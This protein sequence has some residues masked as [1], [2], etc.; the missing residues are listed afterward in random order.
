MKKLIYILSGL[1]VLQLL[2][3]VVVNAQ[4]SGI[5]GA[6]K[7]KALLA[8]QDNDI[9]HI[10]ISGND[11][12]VVNLARTN[13]KWLLS[14]QSDFPANQQQVTSLLTQILSLK[15][16]LAVA[17][18]DNAAHRFKVAKDSFERKVVLSQQHVDMATLYLGTSA[19]MRET[20]LRLEGEAQVYL[21]NLPV[22]R[23]PVTNKEWMQ[24]DLL[25]LK[26]TNIKALK[27][28]DMTLSRKI[29]HAQ[30]SASQQ[31]LPATI[32]DNGKVQ[33]MVDK[34][35][36]DNGNS[37]DLKNAASTP[38]EN[39]GWQ[40]TP[41]PAGNR[42]NLGAVNQALQ[43]LTSLRVSD[44]LGVEQKANFGLDTPLL[45][46]T[47]QRNQGDD[48]NYRLGQMSDSKD[49]VLKSSLS[50]QYFRLPQ[51]QGA[52]FAAAFNPSAFS[53]PLTPAKTDKAKLG[54]NPPKTVAESTTGPKEHVK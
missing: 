48:V 15:H 32:A 53:E 16:G 46:L 20:H 1:L 47:V 45:Q 31:P 49:Y 17:D 25:Q 36:D 41:L 52:A 10:S 9:D 22:Y 6:A 19:S 29:D 23:L 40:L 35:I 34:L 42:V 24:Q 2:L 39:S 18:S 5:Q 30:T 12:K 7:P 33:K 54:S 3:T 13:D 38:P 14:D 28:G 43:Q 26:T 11:G 21:A 51:A 8:L 4:H 50:Q 44:L 27:I 37:K